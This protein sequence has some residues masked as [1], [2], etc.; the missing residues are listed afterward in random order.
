MTAPLSPVTRWQAAGADVVTI[1]SAATPAGHLRLVAID[2]AGRHYV[3]DQAPDGRL[4]LLVGPVSPTEALDMACRVL[5][6]TER[7]V[8]DAGIVMA[9]ALMVAA[10]ATEEAAP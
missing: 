3:A 1:A 5:V 2:E 8:S 7:S 6:G 4:T 10:A 9:G